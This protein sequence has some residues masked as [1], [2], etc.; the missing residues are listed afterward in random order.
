M[1]KIASFALVAVFLASFLPQAMAAFTAPISETVVFGS[2][3]VKYGT[4]T[5]NGGSTGGD[6]VT[7]MVA[8]QFCSLQPNGAAVIATQSVV[9]ETMPLVNATGA[10]TIVTSANEVGNFMCFG[11]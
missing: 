8:V 5:N 6:I 4:Y 3:L 9:N 10:V 2:K 1:K 11:F 7:N